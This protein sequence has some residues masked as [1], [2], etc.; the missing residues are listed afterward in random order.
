MSDSDYDFDD[1]GDIADED[2]HAAA[3]QVEEEYARR[4]QSQAQG[5]TQ[6]GGIGG[7]Q[8]LFPGADEDVDEIEEPDDDLEI[9]AE[10]KN[11]QAARIQ[12]FR[13][14]P[15]APLGK[16]LRQSTL[17]GSQVPPQSSQSSGGRSGGARRN[18]PLV[19]SVSEEPLTHHK[20]DLEAAKTWVYPTNVGHRDYQFNIVQRAL[21]SNLLVALPTG[22]GKTFIAAAV[23]LN[24]FRWAPESQI[25]FL[26]PT[27]PLVAQQIE[28]CFH[29]TG[30]PRN[31]TALMTGGVSAALRREYWKEKRVF[32]TTPQTMQNDIRN[33]IC[34]PNKIVCLVIDEAHK[35]TGKYSY[36]EV[37]KL[38][39]R[40]NKSFR[41][42]ALTATPGSKVE[43]VQEVIDGCGI[44]R[45]EIRTEESLDIRQYVHQKH[46]EKQV[47][48]LP[49]E[50]IEL[51]DLYCKCLQPLLKKLN[52]AKAYWQTNPEL[53]TPFGV[54]QA[55][56][57]WLASDVGRNANPSFKGA[58][59]NSFAMLASLAHPLG[60]L[61]N[62][63][64]RMFNSAILHAEAEAGNG[65]QRNEFFQS[66]NFKKVRLKAQALVNDP[67]C[68]GHPKLDHLAGAVLKHFAEAEDEDAK[69]ETRI[70]IFTTYR[71]SG[72]EI[73]KLL[74]KHQ[75]MVKAHMFVGQQDSKSGAGMTQKAQ[76]ETIKKFQEGTFNTLVATSIGEE[77]LDI[78]E[79]DLI[80][81]YDS[82][83]SPIKMLQRM[84]RTGRKRAGYVL[85]LLTKGKEEDSFKKAED[86]YQYM[87]RLITSRE[88]FTFHHDLSP[89]ILP[90]DVKP[91][92]EKRFIDVPPENSQPEPKRSRAKAS[93]KSKPIKKF[94]MPEGAKT[95]FVKASRM[96]KHD[97]SDE[98]EDEI[99]E[100]LAPVLDNP[101][102]GL[103]TEQEEEALQRRYRNIYAIDE[104]LQVIT[105]PQ[106]DAFPE[107]QRN[108]TKAKFVPH[109]RASKS[110]VKMLRNMR[111]VDKEVLEG[112][113]EKFDPELLKAPPPKKLSLTKAFKPVRPMGKT[114]LTER[115]PNAPKP[116]A[117]SAA[118]GKRKRKD[119]VEDD[120]VTNLISSSEDEVMAETVSLSPTSGHSDNVDSSLSTPKKKFRTGSSDDELPDIAEMLKQSNNKPVPKKKKIATSKTAAAKKSTAA[121]K[122]SVKGKQVTQGAEGVDSDDEG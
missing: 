11:A 85:L 6:N 30:I 86:N 8:S 53:L 99:Q 121:T 74:N 14:P 4:L 71:E 46:V 122:A 36:V 57:Q 88:S 48:E 90:K 26:A 93:N 83:A 66:A 34:D 9:A 32:F 15:P 111:S 108:L 113:Q 45:I 92:V 13:R 77:G 59:I 69:R 38:L 96:V 67:D 118:G 72:L 94:F 104:E 25:A 41:V 81:C 68:L 84:G 31:M 52:D 3:T 119:P 29:Q 110:L 51:R 106:L 63:G 89:R 42:L 79:V 2:L 7:T 80:I 60:L 37:V 114:G 105:A 35:T 73:V 27:K 98:D 5:Q 115:A 64:V 56:V 16:N 112:F 87:Q 47:F 28:A 75:P 109:G 22:L 100:E 40:T 10:F 18:W 65:R 20:I 91:E 82:S 78:G 97:T 24:W 17:F 58:M 54:Q 23:M 70:M 62:H 76:V 49:D 116:K 50:I 55:K 44:A 43:T 61:S 19:N 120:I 103:L 102:I 95:G 117:L 33:E 39:R 107:V 12:Q 101:E 21:F 1:W